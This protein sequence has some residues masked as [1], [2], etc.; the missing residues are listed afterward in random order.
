MLRLR[1]EFYPPGADL[2]ADKIP[3]KELESLVREGLVRRLEKRPVKGGKKKHK[4]V[5]RFNLDPKELKE[6]SLTKLR[7]LVQER[8]VNPP[9][10]A[11]DCIALLSKD[12]L[13]D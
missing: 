7:I 10:N 13:G 3:E 9:D 2:P 1:G 6:L 8:G 4:R 11:E 5:T 12:Y